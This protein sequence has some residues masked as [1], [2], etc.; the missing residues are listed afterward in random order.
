[1]MTYSRMYIDGPQK[2]RLPKT[3]NLIVIPNSGDL[4]RTKTE[5]GN[6]GRNGYQ[7]DLF[8][9]FSTTAKIK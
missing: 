2:L 1:M 9:L 3:N 5:A 8:S 4:F 6:F 7:R